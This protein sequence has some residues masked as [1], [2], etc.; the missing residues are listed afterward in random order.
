MSQKANSMLRIR[1]NLSLE[2]GDLHSNSVSFTNLLSNF[3]SLPWVGF[4]HRRKD[5]WTWG[6]LA[7]INSLGIR[8]FS[9][10]FQFL[11]MIFFQS[12]KHH[13]LFTWVNLNKCLH[14]T[15]QRLLT[16]IQINQ[17][18]FDYWSCTKKKFSKSKIFWNLALPRPS[19][20]LLLAS[21]LRPLSPYSSSPLTLSLFLPSLSL[22]ISL[23]LYHLLII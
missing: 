22:P 10:Q 15:N 21:S 11:V 4:L 16:H 9:S 20:S 12:F 2:P 23:S 1:R 8:L 13:S 7:W 18:T 3:L 6:S 17:Y 5:E 14:I 19:P